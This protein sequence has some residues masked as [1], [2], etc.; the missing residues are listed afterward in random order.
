VNWKSLKK[1]FQGRR[2]L[3]RPSFGLSKIT[4]SNIGA[5]D[6]LGYVFEN[7]ALSAIYAGNGLGKTT[8][9]ECMSLVGHIPCLPTLSSDKK[10]LSASRLES[11]VGCLSP[12]LTTAMD[13]LHR[14]N[15]DFS[16]IDTLGM[17]GWMDKF[18][19]N[20]D[21]NYGFV[22]IQ[23]F[24]TNYGQVVENSF[25]II[26]HH[27]DAATTGSP[28]LTHALS[29]GDFDSAS[30]AGDISFCD[31]RSLGMSAFMIF[32]GSKQS[33]HQTFDV[34]VEKIAKGR[35]FCVVSNKSDR[36]AAVSHISLKTAENIE[37]RAVSYINTDLN[38][39]GRGND[40]RESPKDL[41]KDFGQEVLTRLRLELDENG[42][43]ANFGILA[44]ICTDVLSTPVSHY[45][46]RSAIPPLFNLQALQKQGDKVVVTINRGDGIGQIPIDF[47]SAGE[48]EVFFVFLLLLNF[49]RNPII[50]KSI[51][52]LDEPDL[53][54]ANSARTLFF[55][56]IVDT[57][58][59]YSQLIIS[60]HSVALYGLALREW[61]SPRK[62][63]QVIY[64]ELDPNTKKTVLKADYDETY[65]RKVGLVNI[66]QRNF[67]NTLRSIHVYFGRQISR[68]RSAV[69]IVGPSYPMTVI[70]FTWL[71]SAFSFLILV[72]G[73][74]LNDVLNGT[75]ASEFVRTFLFFG[76]DDSNYHAATR[77]S[78]VTTFTTTAIPLLTVLKLRMTAKCLQREALEKFRRK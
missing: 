73:A 49:T 16:L 21:S 57:A 25:L 78:L 41:T 35:T 15:L 45:T 38:D 52:L 71:L 24:D 17:V 8:L 60:S 54:I 28:K 23:L 22:Y 2:E 63:F 50:G 65:L 3:L 72:F 12:S 68:T 32:D 47:L 53:H 29:R 37:P 30:P 69:G 42:V 62:I 75:A 48:N 19:P 44:Q 39:F 31:D 70:F 66:H 11:E 9:L 55:K 13:I 40:L 46:S 58:E 20:N 7:S 4:I 10:S 51:I 1:T 6:H 5:I 36:L 76:H 18:R 26:V 64:R 43:F 34:L 56:N 74:L 14:P 59:T 67:I 61:Y 77:F 27:P 33:I